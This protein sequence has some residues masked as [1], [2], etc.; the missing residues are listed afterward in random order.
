MIINNWDSDPP[1]VPFRDARSLFYP[2]T[3]DIYRRLPS[4][5]LPG[6]STAP[7]H[8]IPF[9]TPPV[10]PKTQN[11]PKAACPRNFSSAPRNYSTRKYDMDLL[12]HIMPTPTLVTPGRFTLLMACSTCWRWQS[13]VTIVTRLLRNIRPKIKQ[14]YKGESYIAT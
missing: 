6:V 9:R 2:T 13:A 1:A 8:A 3:V 11:T 10:E 7:I 4:P 5:K 12:Q 14:S